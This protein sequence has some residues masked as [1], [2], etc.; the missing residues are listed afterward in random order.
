L[1]IY[2]RNIYLSL[3]FVTILV[4]DSVIKNLTPQPPSLPAL[5]EPNST[6]GFGEGL[7]ERFFQDY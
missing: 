5:G 4:I 1:R 3:L 7:G 2:V 6:L